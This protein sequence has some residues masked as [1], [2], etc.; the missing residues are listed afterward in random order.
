[1][2]IDMLKYL[3]ELSNGEVDVINTNTF[4][5]HFPK[6]SST[7]KDLQTLKSLGFIS[8]LNADNEISCIGINQKA[9]DYFK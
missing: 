3:V 1:M 4:F 2:N 7:N 6:S 5:E 9:I 8:L